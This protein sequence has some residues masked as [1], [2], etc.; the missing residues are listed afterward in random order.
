MAFH[1]A[2]SEGW[3]KSAQVYDLDEIRLRERFLEPR[4]RG[5]SVWLGGEGYDLASLKV[6]LQIREG[7]PTVDMEDFQPAFGVEWLTVVAES[8]DVTDRFVT[9]PPGKAPEK[10]AAVPKTLSGSPAEENPHVRALAGYADSLERYMAVLRK[11]GASGE[12]SADREQELRTTRRD[13]LEREA[14]VVRALE[15]TGL[16]A[17]LPTPPRPED[18]GPNSYNAFEHHEIGVPFEPYAPLEDAVDRTHA[19][20]GRLRDAETKSPGA[21]GLPPVTHPGAP[22]PSSSAGDDP[23]VRWQKIAV[24]VGTTVSLLGIAVTIAIASLS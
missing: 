22:S 12:A 6:K 19:A 20:I 1:V 7:S 23:G 3:T 21:A 16:D 2:V 13:L 17:D 15:A 11:E 24:I 18:V 10:S 4:A 8:K 14:A 9:G 5:E